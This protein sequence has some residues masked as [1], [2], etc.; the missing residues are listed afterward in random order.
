[1]CQQLAQVASALVATTLPGGTTSNVAAGMPN[2]FAAASTLPSPSTATTSLHPK[3]P[4]QQQASLAVVWHNVVKLMKMS[5]Q[6]LGK[7]S[8][9]SWMPPVLQQEWSLNTKLCHSCW[10]M[11]T[12]PHQCLHW[13]G[14]V[15]HVHALIRMLLAILLFRHHR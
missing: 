13:R 14:G 2:D 1:M 8:S 12:A 10:Q 15:M 11:S 5:C 4:L 7:V 6:V 9:L 3:V